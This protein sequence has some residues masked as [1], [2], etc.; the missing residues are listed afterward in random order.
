MCRQ[1]LNKWSPYS[2]EALKEGT[3]RE[4]RKGKSMRMCR[5]IIALI[6]IL[7]CPANNVRAESEP[8][9]T[10]AAA[11]SSR[12][13]DIVHRHLQ[14]DPW[15]IERLEGITSSFSDGSSPEIEI[16]YEIHNNK[17]GNVNITLFEND[18]V[19][20]VTDGSLSVASQG[21]NSTAIASQ[22]DLVVYQ[23]LLDVDEQNIYNSNLWTPQSGDSNFEGAI[24]FCIRTE[25]QEDLGGGVA[26]SVSY[27]ET[28]VTL[29]V[30]LAE[31]FTM[32]DI[33]TI[34]VT[35]DSETGNFNV[36]YA[37]EACHCDTENVCYVPVEQVTMS[38]MLRLCVQSASTEVVVEAITSMELKQ[39]IDNDPNT[40]PVLIRTPVSSGT[41]DILSSLSTFPEG[42][43]V[44]E[45]R[46]TSDFFSSPAPGTIEAVGV[47]RLLFANGTRRRLN[48]F[49][50]DQLSG[51][52][53]FHVSIPV[54]P[55]DNGKSTTGIVVGITSAFTMILIGV[56]FIVF[57]RK[58]TLWERKATAIGGS[59]EDVEPGFK[60]SGH[61]DETA[62]T[63]S[64]SSSRS[65][66]PTDSL[67][68]SSAIDRE[69]S[70]Y[71]E[72]CIA[73]G[74]HE[75]SQSRQNASKSLII[76]KVTTLCD[77]QV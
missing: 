50:R 42:I 8:Q 41:P 51:T 58:R 59:E 27:S 74:W 16:N 34:P 68:S 14:S 36:D 33:G 30:T 32:L 62:Y 6:V 46:L 76:P 1:P 28:Q 45:T 54:K 10:L 66:A 70:V 65:S 15:H 20:V 49:S 47:V 61:S 53:P 57:R 4:R 23:V 75:R 9:L 13:T 64:S 26:E 52:S 19:T 31:D 73:Y 17:T 48:I 39:D 21:V 55:A 22:T 24:E 56:V 72:F 2:Q 71:N 25:L 60:S 11:S 38:S 37:I 40:A 43:A 5:T 35:G 67:H 44:I 77:P 7:V 69:D 29:Q 63:A 12:S 3:R 18:C